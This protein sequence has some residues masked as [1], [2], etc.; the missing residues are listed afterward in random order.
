MILVILPVASSNNSIA[1]D[2]ITP[3]T[4]MMPKKPRVEGGRIDF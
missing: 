2:R 3:D 1:F 4:K